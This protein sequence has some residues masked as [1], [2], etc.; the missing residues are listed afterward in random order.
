MGL[1]IQLAAWPFILFIPY[2]ILWNAMGNPILD[3]V[4]M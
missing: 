4:G 1:V 2:D 3:P